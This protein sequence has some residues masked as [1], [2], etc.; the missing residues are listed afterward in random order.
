[1]ELQSAVFEYIEAFYNRQRRHPEH[2]LPSQLLLLIALPGEPPARVGLGI[3]AASAVAVAVDLTIERLRNHR[4]R[5]P[6]GAAITALLC[7][8]IVSPR[9]GRYVGPAAAAIA[10]ASKHLIRVRWGSRTIHVLNPAAAGLLA[11]LIL[12]PAGQSWWGALTN[13]PEIWI[14]AL[15]AIGITVDRHVARLPQALAFFATYFGLFT[16]IAFT[17]MGGGVLS[18]AGRLS[19]VYRPPL[20]NAALFFT[21]FMPADPPTSPNREDEQLRFGALAGVI[22]VI[23]YLT[24]HTLAF[25]PAGLL[26]ANLTLAWRRHQQ[27]HAAAP[28]CPAHAQVDG[29]SPTPTIP[30]PTAGP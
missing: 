6:D 14:L 21:F 24:L 22:A 1:V 23:A 27:P 5:V 2:A 9:A 28:T 7:A 15:I 25:L 17:T 26:V 30:I 19:D 13:R 29:K 10:I 8:L 20:V 4:W 12:F 11:T 3:L 16:T 18:L